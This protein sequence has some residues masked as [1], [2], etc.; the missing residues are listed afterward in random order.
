MLQPQILFFRYYF[1]R[2]FQLAA[3]VVFAFPFCVILDDATYSVC[4]LDG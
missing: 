1:V 2:G 3:F 4:V